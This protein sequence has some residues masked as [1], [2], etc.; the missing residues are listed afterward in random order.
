MGTVTLAFYAQFT[1]SKAGLNGLSPVWDVERVTR[2]DG[3]RTALQTG[4]ATNITVGRR[5]L[6]GYYQ[7]GCDLDLY[8]YV[9]TAITADTSVD[10][11]EVPALWTYWIADIG[12]A[13]VASVTGA[14]GS[15]TGNVGGNV[16]GSVASVSG[17]VGS[18]TGAVTVATNNDKTGY[19]L[20]SA[21]DAAKT[22]ASS[23]DYT[24]ARAAKLDNLDATVT[25]R[26][27][28]ASYSA[29]DNASV[30][31][32]KA[33]T[34]SLTFT[35]TDVRATLDGETVTASSVTDKSGY[36]LATP[37]PTTAAIVA[38][39]D[40]SSADLDTLITNL[41]TLLARL[42]A[43]RAGNLDNLT[44]PPLT[45][46]QTANAV[47]DAA[48]SDHNTT[49]SIGA[50]INA[51]GSAA[52]PLLNDPATYPQGTAGAAL[53]AL[54]RGVIQVVAPVSEDGLTIGPLVAGDD[55][56]AVDGAALEWTFPTSFKPASVSEATVTFRVQ[57]P[58]GVLSKTGAL[59]SATTPIVVRVELASADTVTIPPG[60]Y[61]FSLRVILSGSE[62]RRTFV[63]EGILK[64]RGAI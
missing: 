5:G 35:G 48:G 20:T 28:G 11:K 7:T 50:K 10:L 59:V 6:Y 1:A 49:G 60:D 25:S 27:A 37:P 53:N 64:L 62:R 21:Y 9:A 2:A 51:A 3:T 34:D 4:A 55:Y 45:A 31:A 43:T 12:D 52:D 16:A 26:L 54:T 15:V 56:A 14:V 41:S 24:A 36:S 8:D 22:S 63:R 33:K 13:S 23:A 57:H 32:I 58:D 29:P 18:V 19:A 44:T 40:A 38:A 30:T 42:T 47:L 17:A 46:T 61:P 39:M